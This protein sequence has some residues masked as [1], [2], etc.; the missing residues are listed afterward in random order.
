MALQAFVPSN[1]DE[2]VMI[3]EGINSYLNKCN[4]ITDVYSR[5]DELFFLHVALTR[6]NLELNVILTQQQAKQLSNRLVYLE[7]A[8]E[9]TF[10]EEIGRLQHLQLYER[11]Q[12][13]FHF[14]GFKY[15]RNITKGRE[16]GLSESFQASLGYMIQKVRGYSLIYDYMTNFFCERLGIP[17]EPPLT[18]HSGQG[19]REERIYIHTHYFLVMSD[20]FTTSCDKHNTE[21]LVQDCEYAI[22][23]KLG[24]LIAELFWALNYYRYEGPLME[25]LRTFL[26]QSYCKG[27]WNYG[28]EQDRQQQHA[29]YSTIVAL[30]EYLKNR[31][32]G[33]E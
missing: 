32:E 23:H 13:V 27:L 16:A 22:C 19:S 5:F 12:I 10:D 8:L 7:N 33:H 25:R 2:A 20:Y 15:Y 4:Q 26:H 17:V 1:R 29:Q 11:S 9:R 21:A 6:Y 31:S 14:L 24:D 3:R 30:L 18:I 28:Y